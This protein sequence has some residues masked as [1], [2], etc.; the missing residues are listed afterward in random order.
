MTTRPSGG[1]GRS[2]RTPGNS[3]DC[4]WANAVDE[5]RQLL[6]VEGVAWLIEKGHL[7]E[8]DGGGLTIGDKPYLIDSPTGVRRERYVPGSSEEEGLFRNIRQ[9]TPKRLDLLRESIATFGDLRDFFPV[10][11]DEDGNIVDGR[12]RRAIDPDWPAAHTVKVSPVPRED[13]VAAAV[14]EPRERLGCEGLEAAL[15]H[16]EFTK[17]RKVAQSELARP[18]AARGRQPV[19]PKDR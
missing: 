13:R 17:G 11:E 8:V 5:G 7:R 18:G 12:H 15:Q 1:G 10:L 3:N 2:T 4:A 6:A 14:V 16:A 19:Q 9:V